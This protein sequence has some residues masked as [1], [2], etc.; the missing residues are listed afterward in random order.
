[1]GAL[2]IFSG[3]LLAIKIHAREFDPAA[4]VLAG[5]TEGRSGPGEDNIRIF[6]LHEGTRVSIQRSEGAW[7]LVRLPSGIGGWVRAKDVERI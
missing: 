6:T 2:L 4:I 3:S 7:Y 1:M 5:E